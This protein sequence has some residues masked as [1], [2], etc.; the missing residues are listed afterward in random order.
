MEI[1][2]YLA[3]IVIGMS[4]GI[5]IGVGVMTISGIINEHK[6]TQK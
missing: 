4:I 3:G 5:T 1:I 6:G 2:Y